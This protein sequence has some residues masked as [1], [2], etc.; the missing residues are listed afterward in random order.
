MPEATTLATQLDAVSEQIPNAIGARID[1]ALAEVA[2][3]GRAPGLSVGDRAP[4]FTAT[5]HDGRQVALKDFRGKKVLLYFYPR[6]DTPGCT[7][8]GIGFRDRIGDFGELGTVILGASFD[9]P[10][11]N[12]AFAKKFSFPFLL[13][14]D[15]DKS[16]A[17]KYG[18]AGAVRTRLA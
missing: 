11:R 16:L 5:A 7:T 4:D 13:L 3:S 12:A 2:K 1:A 8:E 18:A 9:T 14:S 10:E 15:T 17:I 6:A